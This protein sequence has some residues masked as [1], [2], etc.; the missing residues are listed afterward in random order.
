[1]LRG[2]QYYIT[3]VEGYLDIVCRLNCFRIDAILGYFL[4]PYKTKFSTK[5]HYFSATNN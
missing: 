3:F 1:V 4:H 2:E 5:A